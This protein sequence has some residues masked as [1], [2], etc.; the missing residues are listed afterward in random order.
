LCISIPENVDSILLACAHVSLG[1]HAIKDTLELGF[2]IFSALCVAHGS[3]VATNYQEGKLF[4]Q[5]LSESNFLSSILLYNLLELLYFLVVCRNKY[6]SIF[7][8]ISLWS[9][10]LR[11]VLW[12]KA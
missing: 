10:T 4:I 2:D 11:T 12:L 1:R 9:D 3:R 7:N 6:F 5:N 8:G